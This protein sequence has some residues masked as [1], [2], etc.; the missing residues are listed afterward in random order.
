MCARACVCVF[1]SRF[2]CSCSWCWAPVGLLFRTA[3]GHSENKRA[4]LAQQGGKTERCSWNAALHDQQ[5]L[6]ALRLS[7]ARW[8]AEFRSGKQTTIV[9]ELAAAA[10]S[11]F[12]RISHSRMQRPGDKT[13]RTRAA[14][15][16]FG[17]RD[18]SSGAAAA[19][20]ST[21]A[22]TST[23]KSR[24]RRRAKSVNGNSTSTTST[25]VG[26]SS[27][28][29]GSND[30]KGNSLD[31]DSDVPSANASQASAAAAL[32]AA[33]GLAAAVGTPPAAA[34][35]KPKR[36]RIDKS[37]LTPAERQAVELKKREDRAR[38]NRASALKSRNKRRYQL[39]C[40]CSLAS[41]DATAAGALQQDWHVLGAMV[42]V[43]LHASMHASKFVSGVACAL[44][45]IRCL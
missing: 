30:N 5:I 14:K 36:S 23:G 17:R 44:H 39:V 27:S 42:S 37:K 29:N 13:N 21:A 9:L 18:E 10:F 34:Q 24:A 2:L 12:R 11:H 15:S 4:V 25:S 38:R 40:E 19:P 28:D 6:I 22:S 26:T 8:L 16:K 33:D 43:Y 7:R 31:S 3:E 20:N 32:A 41:F 1:G 35:R 45:F